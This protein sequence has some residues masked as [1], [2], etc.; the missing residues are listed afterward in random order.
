MTASTEWPFTLIPGWDHGQKDRLVGRSQ[1]QF[2][3]AAPDSRWHNNDGQEETSH[4]LTAIIRS[5][6]V[7]TDK[8]GQKRPGTG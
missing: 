5:R 4:L 3:V 2:S 6:R 8:M 1:P 7:H